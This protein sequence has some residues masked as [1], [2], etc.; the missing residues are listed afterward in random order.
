LP[1]LS[2]ASLPLINSHGN[3]RRAKITVSNAPNDDCNGDYHFVDIKYNGGYFVK[4]TVQEDGQYCRMVLA[5]WRNV[6]GNISQFNWY[7]YSSTAAVFKPQAAF[8]EDGDVC[9]YANTT[10]LE[11]RLPVGLSGGWR[12]GRGNLGANVDGIEVTVWKDE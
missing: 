3:P 1:V 7:I 9:Y 2:G 4:H 8:V 12:L 11:C 10:T 5:K 6:I